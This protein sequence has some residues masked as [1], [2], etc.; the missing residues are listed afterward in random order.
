M[1]VEI[2]QYWIKKLQKDQI[3]IPIENGC[4]RVQVKNQDNTWFAIAILPPNNVWEYLLDK[5]EWK[6]YSESEAL[7]RIRL[8]SFW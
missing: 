3:L 4:W 7:R 2:K 5:E 8:K 1:N 6:F